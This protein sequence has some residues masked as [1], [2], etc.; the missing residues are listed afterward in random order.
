MDVSPV[1]SP[2][3]KPDSLALSLLKE[4]EKFHCGNFHSFEVILK[5]AFAASSTGDFFVGKS[6][7][8]IETPMAAIRSS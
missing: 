2:A 8:P 6:V 1:I 5:D 4:S 7:K 3:F